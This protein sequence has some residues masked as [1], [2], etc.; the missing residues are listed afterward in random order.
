MPNEYAGLNDDVIQ[1]FK[2]YYKAY[3][4]AAMSDPND[5]WY[6]PPKN[7]LEYECI[8]IDLP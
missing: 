2:E 6:C 3:F 1:M 8:E 4:E 5:P 7:N